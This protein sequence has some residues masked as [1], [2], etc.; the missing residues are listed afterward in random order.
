[1]SDTTGDRAAVES[2]TPPIPKPVFEY[3]INPLM[4]AL[5]RSPV[6][7]LVS[8]TLLLITY[9]GRKSGRTYTTPVGYEELDGTLYVTSQ[10][11]RVW[12][13]NLRGGAEVEV[14]LRGDRRVGHAEVIEDNESVADYLLGF[15]DRHGVDSLSRLALSVRDDELPDGP[16]LAVGLEDVAV[17]QIEP[18]DS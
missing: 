13:K 8:D 10:T 9:T 12:W 11:D 14:R 4:K 17:I 3:L 6:H 5:L 16:E 18:V 15:V 7:G 2:L 1:M